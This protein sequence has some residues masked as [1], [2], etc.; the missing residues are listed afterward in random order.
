MSRD[1]GFQGAVSA[2]ASF[3]MP[4]L[5]ALFLCAAS[6]AAATT[7]RLADGI[8]N[9]SASILD[10]SWGFY[11]GTTA[12]GNVANWSE[13]IITN[14]AWVSPTGF[15]PGWFKAS[16][17][18]SAFDPGPY[19]ALLWQLGDV[20]VHNDNQG[21]A[22]GFGAVRFTSASEVTADVSGTT[23]KARD[24]NRVQAWEIWVSQSGVQQQLA[25][26]QVDT[27]NLGSVNG[28]DLATYAALSSI[29][30]AAGDW[31]E[32]RTYHA[33]GTTGDRGFVGLDLT[34]ETAAAPSAVPLPAS[35][36]LFAS[37]LGLLGLAGWRRRRRIP[38]A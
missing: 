4:A 26:G 14:N 35:L 7:Y 1:A 34:V 8:S 32:Y 6:P 38:R 30:L 33:N 23:W 12:L 21:A 28:I 20:V 36:P 11:Q 24:N 31:I 29:A 10:P 37:G 13:G 3:A 17:D 27:S 2:L 25:A 5:V 22:Y 16:V 9:D 19:G 15:V 18:P